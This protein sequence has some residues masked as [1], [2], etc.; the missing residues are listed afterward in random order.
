M[1]PWIIKVLYLSKIIFVD[2]LAKKILS[3][4]SFLLGSDGALVLGKDKGVGLSGGI[5]KWQ[6]RIAKAERS[7]GWVEA[8]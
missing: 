4:V 1:S 2:S 7:L 6:V 5:L 8:D 3:T